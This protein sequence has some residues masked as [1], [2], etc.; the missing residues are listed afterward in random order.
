MSRHAKKPSTW[1][2]F[3]GPD[4]I[5]PGFLLERPIVQVLTGSA[6]IVLGLYLLIQVPGNVDDALAMS[7]A[8]ECAG[9]EEADCFFVQRAIVTGNHGHRKTSRE[10]WDFAPELGAAT[11]WQISTPGGSSELQ[12]GEQVDLW[13]WEGKPAAAVSADGAHGLR[14]ITYGHGR[15]VWKALVVPLAFAIG[16]AMLVFGVQNRRT[17]LGWFRLPSGGDT[18]A[19]SDSAAAPDRTWLWSRLPAA[20]R[21]VLGP[22][23]AGCGFGLAGWIITASV[24]ITMWVVLVG[25]VGT[26]ALAM[27]RARAKQPPSAW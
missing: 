18:D 6:A 15:W 12:I 26:V 7:D 9:R 27:G 3:R 25:F 8:V 17:G 20:V 4:W 23:L 21:S 11:A 1:R 13:L 24:T 19:D 22:L 14:S 10:D 5:Q 16:P 2:R